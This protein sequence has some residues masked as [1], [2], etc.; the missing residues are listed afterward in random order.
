MADEALQT[1][2]APA[3]SAFGSS[4]F[5]NLLHKEFRPKSDQAKTAVESAVKTLAEQALA[6]TG[7]I[8]DDALRSIE[9]I[10]AEIDKKLTEQ[11]NLILHN[12]EFQQLESAWRGLHY[13]V[14]NTE[15]DEMLKIRVIP[16]TKK[17]LGKSLAKF[18]GTAMDQSPIFKKLYTEEF[19]QLGGEPYG[20]LVADF[21]WARCQRLPLQPMR[22]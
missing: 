4:E 20:S 6:N 5:A 19:S 21:H 15:T 13:L 17:E 7:L 8:S 14:N 1:E 10:V 3:E 22:P 9:S 2:A 16:I 11:V 18:K 12:K